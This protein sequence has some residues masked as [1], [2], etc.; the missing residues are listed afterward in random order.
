LKNSAFKKKLYK[1]RPAAEVKIQTQRT[2]KCTRA[3]PCDPE[4]L[5]RGVRQ[6]LADKVC[7][8]LVGLWLLIPEHLRLGTWDLLCGWTAQTGDRVEPRLAL[9]LVHEAALCSTGLRQQRVL[10]QRGFELANGLPFVASDM[11]IHNLLSQHTVA[12]S[13]RLQVALGRIRRASG[14]YQARLLAID[15]HRVRSYS[16]RQMRRYRD[17][18]KA[19][20][21]KVAQTFFALDP[22][23]H[24]PVCFTT[25]TSARTATTAAVEL[26][27]L[28]GEI[29]TPQPGQTLVMADLEHE[30]A[31]LFN[32]VRSQTPFDLLVPMKNTQSLQ[33]QLRAIPG[34]Q[35][36]RRW[37]GF[38]TMKQPYEMQSRQAADLFQFVQRTGERPDDYRLGA[39]L[40]TTDR[41]EVDA[42]TLHYPKRWHVEEFFNA[43]QALGW[44]RAGTMNLNVRYGQM[45]L[46]LLAQAT[47]HQ[48]RRRLGEPFSNWDANHLSKSLLAGLEGDVRV[49]QDTIV[50]TYYNAPQVERLREHY[51]GLPARLKAENIDPK[52]PWLYGLKLDFRFR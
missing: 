4:S 48:L 41:E 22:D 40:S 1:Y 35:F 14:D 15:P 47:L 31:E 13:Q 18:P 5:Q 7:G 50:V 12:E 11:A 46:A 20:A 33:K 25:A 24:Q 44:N 42:L 36:T 51:H 8:N 26:L 45:T 2:K 23:T 32:H 3:E 17:D 52:I 39:F 16:K 34:E 38:A 43:H 9:Q 28:A 10:S 21:L 29:L 27:H 30:T 19:K 49:E 37:A 6:L